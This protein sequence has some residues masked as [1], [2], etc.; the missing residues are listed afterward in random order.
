M[1]APDHIVEIQFAGMGPKEVGDGSAALDIRNHDVDRLARNMFT[2][3]V[4]A[5]ID[6]DL[7]KGISDRHV[8]L[9]GI[10]GQS[11]HDRRCAIT[12]S[13]TQRQA[14][15]IATVGDILR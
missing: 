12:R 7:R 14:G 10:S 8:D 6:T 1:L 13:C 2:V 9:V 15:W 5:T 3:W 11:I 4:T